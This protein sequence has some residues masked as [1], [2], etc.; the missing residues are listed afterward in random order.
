MNYPESGLLLLENFVGITMELLFSD[1]YSF[2][3]YVRICV[4]PNA[5]LL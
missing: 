4:Q 5:A 3:I 2:Q 1:Y